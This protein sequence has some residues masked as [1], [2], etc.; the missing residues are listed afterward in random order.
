MSRQAFG[1]LAKIREVDA[2]LARTPALQ[3]RVRECHPEVSFRAWAGR[4]LRYGKKSRPGQAER[5]ALIDAEWPGER[6]RL[7]ALLP[8]G[9]FQADDLHDAFAAL[10]T[11]R[12]I[13]D[14][15][16][17]T[18]PTRP[19]QDRCGLAMEIVV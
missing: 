5:V 1:L 7:A 4:G 17:R 11:A 2:L 18:L 16:E 3:R 13:R 10:W 19:E 14:G 12:R 9:A 15:V 6:A 8:R